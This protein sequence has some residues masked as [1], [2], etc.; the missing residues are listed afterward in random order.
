MVAFSLHNWRGLVL[1]VQQTSINNYT[2]AQF[3]IF[4]ET[5]APSAVVGHRVGLKL[6]PTPV[7]GEAVADYIKCR[8]VEQSI[9]FG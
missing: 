8:V 1:I 4:S 9:C 2:N 5:I 6:H 7:G 3:S